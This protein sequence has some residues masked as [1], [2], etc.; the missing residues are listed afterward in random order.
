MLHLIKGDLLQLAVDGRF[1]VIVHGCNCYHTMG[2]GIALQIKEQ[3][4]EAYRVDLRTARGDYNKLGT[5][6][7]FQH[8]DPNFFIVNAYTQFDYGYTTK[9][10][11]EYLA[12]ELILQKLCYQFEGSHMNI[13]F[14]HIGMGKAGGDPPKIFNLLEQFEKQFCKKNGTVTLVEYEKCW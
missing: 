4:P 2:S 3:F 7:V 11:F 12:F 14:P 6:S 13:A 5:Y 8:K 1:Q 10:R 9:D